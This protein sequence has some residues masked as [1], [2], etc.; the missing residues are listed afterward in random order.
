MFSL[1][2]AR[3]FAVLARQ[4]WAEAGLETSYDAGCL[5]G[6]D[7]QMYGLTNVAHNAARGREKHWRPVLTQHVHGVLAAHAT[8]RE[9]DLEVVGDRLL[10][11][12]WATH[13]LP[14]PPECEI[15]LAPGLAGLISIDHPEYVET[16]TR[17]RDIEALGGWE[18]A[19]HLAH[20]NLVR[21]RA[22]R[23]WAERVGDA[24]LLASVGG[25]YNASRVLDMPHLLKSDFLV[26]QPSHGVLFTV[27]NRHL[28]VAHPLQ[29]PGLFEALGALAD[30]AEREYENAAGGI[31][32]HVWFWRDGQVEQ[33]TSQHDDG[34]C[35]DAT[36]LFGDALAELDITRE[37]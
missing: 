5:R 32:P 22:D 21:V 8:P 19:V 27:P 12:L 23:T 17:S 7:G 9:R 14:H 30:L 2:E 37:D 15:P 31:S 4:I 36:G 3:R 25:F 35:V 6:A 1:D 11:R 13:D 28:V 33:T 29:G 16:L 26:D 24:R 10:L 34:L 18:R 20:H